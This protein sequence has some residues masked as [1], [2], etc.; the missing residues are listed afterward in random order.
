[1]DE[2]RTATLV[3][4]GAYDASNVVCRTKPSRVLRSLLFPQTSRKS[5]FAFLTVHLPGLCVFEYQEGEL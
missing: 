3:G 4:I 5:L 1:M 2:R